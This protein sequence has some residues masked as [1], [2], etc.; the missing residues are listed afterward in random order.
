MRLKKFTATLAASAVAFGLTAGIAEAAPQPIKVDSFGVVTGS[1]I[2][3]DYSKMGPY[4][5]ASTIKSQ[6]C[7]PAYQ[8]YNWILKTQHNNKM[9]HTCWG[10][11]PDGTKSPA[12]V[13][14]VYPKNIA[15]MGKRPVIIYTPGIGAEAGLTEHLYRMWASH[16]YIVV[17]TYTFL[18][19]T[20]YTD[21]QGAAHL[22]AE[23]KDASSPLYG[24]I[25]SSR[26]VLTGHSAGG[27]STESGAG[28]LLPSIKKQYPGINIVAAV[29]LQPGPGVFFQGAFVQVPVFYLTGEKDTVCWDIAIRPRYKSVHKA[30][31]W[32]A[33]VKGA[34]HGQEMDDWKYSAFG[35]SVLAFADMYVNNSQHARKYFVGPNYYISKD[36]AFM[37]VE[38]NEQAAALK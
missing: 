31:A 10:T 33:M 5:T 8:V 13:Q 34:P 9:A 15:K 22:L 24:H 28:W 38:R 14:F 20:G 2:Q 27:G 36:A 4:E 32:I 16:G 29:P 21:V 7:G 30:P 25:D 6:P 23:S 11:F 3:N 26:V 35:A 37:R 12:D 17:V 18:N 1:A 19:W